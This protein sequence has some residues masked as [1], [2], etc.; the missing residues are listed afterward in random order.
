MPAYL[1]VAVERATAAASAVPVA[2]ATTVAVEA[3]SALKAGVAVFD[4]PPPPQ[5]AATKAANVIPAMPSRIERAS[6]MVEH[7]T[8]PNLIASAPL[9]PCGEP[10]SSEGK[11]GVT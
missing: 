3:S 10:S 1:A 7:P 9:A 5:A 2:A 11:C 4:D 8:A 6:G